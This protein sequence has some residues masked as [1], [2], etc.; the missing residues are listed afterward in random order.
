MRVRQAVPSDAADVIALFE[1]LYT[2]STF[3]LHEPGEMNRSAETYGKRMTEGFERQNSM[4]FV[5][6][7]GGDLVGIVF[8]SRG[9]AKRTSHSFLLGLGV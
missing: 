7:V 4:M 6:E 8:G 3:L 5:A 2:E 9:L 1:K